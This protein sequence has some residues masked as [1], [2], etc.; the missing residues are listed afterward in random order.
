MQ[1]GK[2]YLVVTF[3]NSNFVTNGVFKTQYVYM[4]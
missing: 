2:Y 3:I 1:V 4:A